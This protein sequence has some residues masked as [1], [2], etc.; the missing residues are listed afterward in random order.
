MTTIV[1]DHKNK[2]IA[3]D[4]R[5]TSG[6]FICSDNTIKHKKTEAGI[7]FVSGVSSD[8][9]AFINKASHN[10]KCDAFVDSAAIFVD[11]KSDV[12][13]VCLDSDNIYKFDI[14]TASDGIGSGGRTAV[15]A[16]DFGVTAKKAAEY[17]ISRDCYSGGKVHVYDIESAEFIKNK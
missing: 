3:C 11:A 8:A 16:L 10:T 9:D 6:G 2:Q 5:E 14:L 12:Y 7:W 15:C 4:S 1:Y 17:A 13:I